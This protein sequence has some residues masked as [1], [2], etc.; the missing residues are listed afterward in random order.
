MNALPARAQEPERRDYA[1]PEEIARRAQDDRDP[2]SVRHVVVARLVEALAGNE[3]YEAVSRHADPIFRFWTL[4]YAYLAPETVQDVLKQAMGE[5]LPLPASQFPPDERPSEHS[6]KLADLDRAITE[7]AVSTH[8]N[9]PV[10][11]LE[12]L[13]KGGA[14]PSARQTADRRLRDQAFR[15]A[16]EEADRITKI[17]PDAPEARM[18]ADMLADLLLNERLTHPGPACAVARALSEK[19]DRLAQVIELRGGDF[20]PRIVTEIVRRYPVAAAAIFRMVLTRFLDDAPIM[21]AI[22]GSPHLSDVLASHLAQNP[23]TPTQALEA[24]SENKN[25]QVREWAKKALADRK[26]NGNARTDRIQKAVRSTPQA[27]KAAIQGTAAAMV[28]D[29]K[30]GG[31]RVDA[32]IADAVAQAQAPVRADDDWL[33]KAPG[34]EYDP[35]LDGDPQRHVV[36]VDSERFVKERQGRAA[37]AG[38]ARDAVPEEH[39]PTASPRQADAEVPAETTVTARRREEIARLGTEQVKAMAVEGVD[40]IERNLATREFSQRLETQA[41]DR[42][43]ESAPA[44][45][46]PALEPKIVAERPGVGDSSSA[47]RAAEQEW[48]GL[49]VAARTIA[50]GG[51]TPE[52][53]ADDAL[54]AQAPDM[55]AR[56]VKSETTVRQGGSVDKAAPGA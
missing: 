20:G 49:R 28:L 44:A 40:D 22:A 30:A 51:V 15:A 39:A 6:K 8:P 35:E 11:A 36:T 55:S 4:A 2:G 48:P 50:A 56:I 27:V 14:N 45:E 32:G 52:P 1:L 12:L 53:L 41:R 47:A 38:T 19:A 13:A 16:W 23:R 43:R 7:L 25:P 34:A 17:G 37:E 5:M 33:E 29:L 3:P 9:A 42:A 24:L 21:A 26:E 10:S 31:Q 46:T 54:S 18:R